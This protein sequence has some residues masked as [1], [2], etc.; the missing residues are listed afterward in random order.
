MR[1]EN[2]I[3]YANAD[4][5]GGDK[6]MK[7]EDIAYIT[8]AFS[9]QY[10]KIEDHNGNFIHVYSDTLSERIELFELIDYKLGV[11]D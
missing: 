9:S 7:I 3:V 10:G 6:E 2:G 5:I 4:H 8:I 1:I 11:N